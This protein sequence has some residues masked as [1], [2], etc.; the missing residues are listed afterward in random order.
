[1]TKEQI[2]RKVFPKDCIW[3]EASHV[4]NA[5]FDMVFAAMDEYVAE[6]RGQAVPLEKWMEQARL[7]A[8]L[9]MYKGENN[10]GWDRNDGLNI[11]IFYNHMLKFIQDHYELYAK[12][13]FN[14]LYS[15]SKSLLR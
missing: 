7:F 5:P 6:V 13:R 8:E 9:M 14:Y 15:Y 1:M 4:D 11:S 10:Q 12:N 2:L 3:E